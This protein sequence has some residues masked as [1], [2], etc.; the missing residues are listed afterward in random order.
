MLA[1]AVL[2]IAAI[3]LLV[4]LPLPRLTRWLLLV[5]IVLLVLAAGDL[6]APLPSRGEVVVMVD[7]SP[8]TRSATYRN[9]ST[10]DAR[11][12][13][14]LGNRSYR[15]VA[16]A[17]DQS[18]LPGDPKLADLPAVQTVFAPPA[19]DAI[20]LLSDGQFDLPPSAPPTYAVIDPGLIEPADASIDNVR[21][22]GENVD[23]TLTGRGPQR[24]LSVT[25]ASSRSIG[26]SPRDTTVQRI[27]LST[28][29]PS[30]RAELSRGDLWPE[31]DVVTFAAPQPPQRQRWWIGDVAPA[32]WTAITP[33]ALNPDD[34]LAPAVIA[35]NNVSADALSPAAQDR[36]QQYV[37]DLGG[38]LLILGGDHAFAA[39]GYTGSTLDALSPLASD[40][41]TPTTRWLLLTDASGSMAADN[42]WPTATNTL[43]S[44]VR[45]LPASDLVSV[46]SFASDLQWWI[47]G[48]PVTEARHKPLPPAGVT[49]SGPTNL[50]PALQKL[51]DG[52]TGDLPTE[53]LVLTDGE[54]TLTNAASLTAAMNAKHLRLHVLAIGSG[55]ALP[56]LKTI[57]DTTG[58]AFTTE[59]NA[60]QWLAAARKLLRGAR[61]EGVVRETTTVNYT[62]AMQLQSHM[63]HSFDR[64]WLKS[65][66]TELAKSAS[67][68][69]AAQ[70]QIGNG[71]VLAT[72]FTP[73][74]SHVQAMADRIAHPPRDPRFRV[75]WQAAG[76]RVIVDAADG[77]HFLN[78]LPL[79]LEL[80]PLHGTV[81]SV[82]LTQTAPGRY[83]TRLPQSAQPR[84]AVLRLDGLEVDRQTIPGRYAREFAG[85]GVDEANLR[86][87]ARRT[88]GRVIGPAESG[89]I[90]PTVWRDA[91]LTPW[92]ASLAVVLIGWS[93]VH[94]KRS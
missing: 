60:A 58:G 64:T 63:I 88:G 8:S 45:E 86:E 47:N 62:A 77:G 74:A 53:L 67:S 66:A 37:R 55:A 14:L 15:L 42:R 5:A 27:H 31:N 41:P 17:E 68:P 56:A 20:V 69:L 57:A 51:V 59:L 76:G 2:G 71:R 54:T 36:L 13:Q 21:V 16:F 80:R 28:M 34:L 48:A 4:R 25:S 12:K 50:E 23:V 89:P 92:L 78:G 19:A 43:V 73:P 35:L 72:A 70:W 65:G 93:L 83:E 87:L 24:V 29:L 11:L 44:V 79:R 32:G 18:P 1:T 61:G 33:D 30:G 7:L 40:P 9:R 22:E 85:I 75:D 82:E 84:L 39:G 49:P 6:H 90:L 52:A 3:G 38:S 91:A 46:G 81:A 26:I 10:L 94:W